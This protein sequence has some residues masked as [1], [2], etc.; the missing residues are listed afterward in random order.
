MASL[1]FVAPVFLK[2]ILC[3]SLRKFRILSFGGP[4]THTAG[5]GRITG[6]D[7][8]SSSWFIGWRKDKRL[9]DPQCTLALAIIAIIPTAPLWSASTWAPGIQAVAAVA[10]ASAFNNTVHTKVI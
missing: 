2:L 6:D 10:A 4:D 5:T 3:S 9:I 7:E 8:I 1:L